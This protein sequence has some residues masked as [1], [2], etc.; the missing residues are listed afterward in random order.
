MSIDG[1]WKTTINSPLGK[2]EGEV[3]LTAN[4]SD[5][6]GEMTGQ[7]QTMAIEN[8]KIDGNNASWSA[9]IAQPMPMTLE[10]NVTISGDDMTGEVKLG[11]F[12]AS[13]LVGTR[14]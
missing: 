12:G 6:T 5:L 4:G 8:G 1:T 14:A 9:K 10:F 3:V 2:Q 7:G 11:A 13:T